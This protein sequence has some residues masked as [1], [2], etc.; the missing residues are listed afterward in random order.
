MIAS[1]VIKFPQTFK[2]K[3][4]RFSR[5]FENVSKKKVNVHQVEEYNRLFLNNDIFIYIY[6]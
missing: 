5:Q 6:K 4:I 1:S 2:E 3:N